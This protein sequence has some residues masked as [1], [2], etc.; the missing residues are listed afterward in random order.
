MWLGQVR[1]TS[2]VFDNKEKGDMDFGGHRLTV[3]FLGM[4]IG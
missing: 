4:K 3:D 2:P 1:T